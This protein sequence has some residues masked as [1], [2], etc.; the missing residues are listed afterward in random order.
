MV[1][2]NFLYQY[3]SA[4]MPS[5]DQRLVENTFPLTASHCKNKAI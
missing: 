5:I 4:I 1:P 3:H 2:P